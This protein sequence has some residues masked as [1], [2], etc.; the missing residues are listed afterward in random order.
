[1]AVVEVAGATVEAGMAVLDAAASPEVVRGR[2]S[3]ELL[4]EHDTE[5]A[6]KMHTIHRTTP[7]FHTLAALLTRTAFVNFAVPTPE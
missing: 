7:K 4:D 1:M 6:T 2:T 5:S 3:S